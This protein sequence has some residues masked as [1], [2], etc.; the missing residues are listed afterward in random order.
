VEPFAYLC[1]LT[2][3]VLGLGITRLLTGCGRLL[4]VRHCTPLYGVHLV[5]TLNLFLFLVLNWWILFRW[6][7]TT[8]WTFFLF[9][10][11][12]LSP[13]IGFLLAVL[14]FPVPM[15]EGLN[16][17]LYYY[18]NHRW[19]F[20]L[21]AALAPI[22]AVDTLLKGWDHFVAQGSLYLLM[23]GLT[24]TL[25]LIAAVTRHPRYHAFFAVF[26]LAFL[27]VFISINLRV[28]G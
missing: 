17:R 19:F 4:Q 3:I 5:W 9:L 16:F 23:L 1:I 2:S 15:A 13:T 11:V 18:A 26:F 21:A 14:L 7:T 12:L 28:L 20:V 24:M 10:F 6:R 8:E 27:L 22:D 25:S